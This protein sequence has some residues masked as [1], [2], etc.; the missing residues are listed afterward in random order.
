MQAA[1]AAAAAAQQAA[2]RASAEA[3]EASAAAAEERAHAQQVSLHGMTPQS[4]PA[5]LK[6]VFISQCTTCKS[7]ST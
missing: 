5:A 7:T 4:R 3:R 1:Q 2:E 6:H